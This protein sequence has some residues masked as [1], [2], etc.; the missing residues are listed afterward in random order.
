MLSVEGV[1]RKKTKAAVTL[2]CPRT[3]KTLD[4]NGSGK[5]W[6]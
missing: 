3:R 2:M 5:R 1:L 6:D 4:G